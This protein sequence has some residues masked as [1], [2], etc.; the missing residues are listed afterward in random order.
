MP[1]KR[2]SRQKTMA[3]A[4]QAAQDRYEGQLAP[5]GGNPNPYRWPILAQPVQGGCRDAHDAAS[6]RHDA[7]D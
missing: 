7:A 3:A 1:G 5:L 4:K 6:P 2:T